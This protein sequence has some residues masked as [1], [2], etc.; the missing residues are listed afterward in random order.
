VGRGHF[1]IIYNAK[2]IF[3]KLNKECESKPD[4]YTPTGKKPVPIE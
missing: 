2:E 4:H 1:I 3:L